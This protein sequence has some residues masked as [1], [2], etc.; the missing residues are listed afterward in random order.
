MNLL[1]RALV[2]VVAVVLL[3]HAGVAQA[4]KAPEAVLIGTSAG[5]SAEH[6]CLQAP[7]TTFVVLTTTDQDGADFNDW[8]DTDILVGGHCPEPEDVPEAILIGTSAGTSA[9]HWCLQPIGAN[10]VGVTTL[11]QDGDGP[12][13]WVDTEWELGG[14]CPEMD[15]LPED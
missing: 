8:V 4:Q 12:S 1:V 3:P 7:G 11:D 9:E 5:T 15:S 6:W 14:V 10:F 13:D 2:V